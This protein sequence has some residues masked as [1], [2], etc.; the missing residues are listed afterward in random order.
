MGPAQF[1]IQLPDPLRVGPNGVQL[2]QTT[3]YEDFGM[4]TSSPSFGFTL[5][6]SRCRPEKEDYEPA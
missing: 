1:N 6:L 3:V 4:L 5:I 2:N